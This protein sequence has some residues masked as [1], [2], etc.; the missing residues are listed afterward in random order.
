V[1]LQVVACPCLPLGVK[2]PACC[3]QLCALPFVEFA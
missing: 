3:R 2:M 1:P